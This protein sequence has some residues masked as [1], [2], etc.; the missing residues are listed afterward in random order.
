M[1]TYWLAIL[2]AF[3]A[4][5]ALVSKRLSTTIFTGPLLFVSFG[6]LMGP[7]VLDLI[8]LQGDPK[9]VDI[10][11]EATLV[12]VLFSDAMAINAKTWRK[13]AYIPERLLGMGLPLTIVLGFVAAM[14]LFGEFNV[15]EAALV[16]AILAPTDAAL[17]QAVISNPRVPRSIRQGLNVE[18]GLN[19]G[20]VFPLVMLLI[21]VTLEAEGASTT[22]NAL[23]FITKTI[24]FSTLVGIAVGWLGG[25]LTEY[26]RHRDWLDPTWSQIGVLAFA[27]LSYG[28]AVPFGGSGFISAWVAGCAFG[29]VVKE[30]L[31]EMSVFPDA[32]GQ[33][34][35][36]LS[37]FVFGNAVLGPVLGSITWEVVLYA[38]LSLTLFRMVPVAVAMV[39]S[40]TK[41][42]SLLYMG[43]F[44]PRGLASIVFAVVIIE[45]AKLPNVPLIVLIMATTV[46]MSVVVH[47]VTA[48]WGSN[49]YAD[50]YEGNSDMHAT[51]RESKPVSDFLPRKSILSYGQEKRAGKDQ[52]DPASS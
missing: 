7:R 11:L 28:L 52:D 46:G 1:N 43:W 39:R 10:L 23:W 26:A 5:Y 51:M 6:L 30:G 13:E 44:G 8:Q 49:R 27:A 38:V 9:T 14:L 45:E 19:D 2:A 20:I 3:L 21:A 18:S 33:L 15:W 41:W 32:L 12:L 48:W 29:I 50:W 47:G 16:G 36:M 37:F 22:G 35:V 24:V 34:L 25:K 17:G 42:P 4:A 40:G 31:E